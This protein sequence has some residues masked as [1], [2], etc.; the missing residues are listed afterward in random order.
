MKKNSK[1]LNLAYD[2][3]DNTS[4]HESE[5]EEEEDSEFLLKRAAQKLELY[6]KNFKPEKESDNSSD[7]NSSQD[8]LDLFEGEEGYEED[9]ILL[10]R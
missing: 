4:D 1:P 8:N 6:E 9:P 5:I 10:K 2:D 7:E 3:D